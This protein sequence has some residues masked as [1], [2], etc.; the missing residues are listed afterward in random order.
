MHNIRHVPANGVHEGAIRDGPW[1]YLREPIAVGEYKEVLYNIAKDYKETTDLSEKQAAVTAQMS[2]L[3]DQL[4]ESEETADDVEAVEG[5]PHVDENG[6]VQ[7]GWC[8]V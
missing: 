8:D 4:A 5:N 6:Y 3:F 2:A 7:T 1:K